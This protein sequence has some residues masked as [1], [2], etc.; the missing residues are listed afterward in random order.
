MSYLMST[1]LCMVEMLTLINKN[2]KRRLYAVFFIILHRLLF[3]EI[4]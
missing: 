1:E 4:L 2:Q 3:S